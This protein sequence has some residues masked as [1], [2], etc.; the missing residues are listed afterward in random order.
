MWVRE[1]PVMTNPDLPGAGCFCALLENVMLKLLIGDGSANFVVAIS[2]PTQ[3]LGP[4]Q[5]ATVPA[6]IV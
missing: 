4:M 3:I 6:M 1:L 5:K 2:V